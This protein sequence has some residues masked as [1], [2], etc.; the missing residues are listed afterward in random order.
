MRPS[1]TTARAPA[2]GTETKLDYELKYTPEGGVAVEADEAAGPHRNAV[3][4]A[5]QKPAKTP[6]SPG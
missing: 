3:D 1:S 6:L 5:L 4:G 2:E